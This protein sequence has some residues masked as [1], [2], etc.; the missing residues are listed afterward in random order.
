M[1]T[2]ENLKYMSSIMG[3]AGFYASQTEWWHFDDADWAYYPVM[4]SNLFDF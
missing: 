1:P 3:Q 4:D 2:Y